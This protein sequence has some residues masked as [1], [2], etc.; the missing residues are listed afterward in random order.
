MYVDKLPELGGQ[1]PPL[2]PPSR[3]PMY[4]RSAMPN[5][6][7]GKDCVKWKWQAD[8]FALA[9][10][11][12]ALLW[13]LNSCSRGAAFV[14]SCPPIFS[15]FHW[16]GQMIASLSKVSLSIP[17]CRCPLLPLSS[18]ASFLSQYS[19]SLHVVCSRDTNTAEP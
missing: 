10:H 2:P 15:T 11:W 16:C 9:L 12:P 8:A 17:E 5:T 7:K 19:T 1:L 13:S 6:K 3:T 18:S 4:V 14:M